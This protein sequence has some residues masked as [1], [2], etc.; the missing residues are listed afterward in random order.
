MNWFGSESS[1]GFWFDCHWFGPSFLPWPLLPLLGLS[2]LNPG[3]QRK[4]DPLPPA[5]ST[6]GYQRASIPFSSSRDSKQSSPNWLTP[7]PNAAAIATRDAVAVARASGSLALSLGLGFRVLGFRL[8]WRDEG[9]RRSAE[10]REM[11]GGRGRARMRPP[12]MLVSFFNYFI[13]ALI[14]I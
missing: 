7:S 1:L 14:T 12:L 9:R 13:N 3:V 10:K 5:A 4:L 8:W 2:K 11:S 6:A